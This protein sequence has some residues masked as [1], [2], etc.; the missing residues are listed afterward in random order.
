MARAFA[1]FMTDFWSNQYR[2]VV[3][4]DLKR[5]MILAK[6]YALQEYQQVAV[7]RPIGPLPIHADRVLRYF[8]P[9]PTD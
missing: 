4:L 5:E 9:S 7:C 3:P 6:P 8:V 2:L 1:K